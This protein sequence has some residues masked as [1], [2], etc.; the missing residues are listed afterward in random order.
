M[1]RTCSLQGFGTR[2]MAAARLM[3]LG[4]L[5]LLLGSG[6]LGN[7]AAQEQPAQQQQAQGQAYT[8]AEYNAYKAA[9]DEK[10]AQQRLKLLDDFMSKYPNSS[11]LGYA[12]RAYYQTYN[13]LKNPPKVMEFADKELALGDKVDPTIKLEAYYLRSVAYYTTF[14][15]K[16]PNAVANATKAR[17]AAQAGLK[18]LSEMKPPQGTT[19]EQWAQTKKQVQPLLNSVLGLSA[20][21]LKDYKTAVEGYKAAIADA[22]TDP[23]LRFRL[24]VAYLQ[25]Q[26]PQTLDG[27]WALA[28]SISLKGPTEAQVRPYLRKQLLNYQQPACEHL[29]DAQM[30]ELISLAA[31]SPTRPDT[32]KFPSSAEL[33]AARKDMTIASVVSDLKAGGDK[34]KIT[35]LAACGLEFPEVPG[36][37]IEVVPGNPVVLKVAFVTSE[38]EFNAAN[39]ANME[40]KIDTQPEAARIEKDNPVHFTGTLS[41][42]DP[43]PLMIHWT[44]AIVN[45]D[46]IPAEKPGKAPR[47]APAKRPAGATR[48]TPAK[49]PA[50]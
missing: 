10:N 6:A 38:A 20:G 46:D 1:R 49:R 15:D 2:L 22:P 18:L 26:P 19:E 32:Y 12:Y 30:N 8:P 28:Q 29:I 13:E 31:T 47:K 7:I 50:S 39:A 41:S 25:M 5:A 37:V 33:E 9:A 42:Y 34:A 48:R 14:N 40:V 16:D 4:S 27:F 44:K 3:A 11:L 21:L 24:G 36:K 43:D 45:K 23:V 17:D 35:W